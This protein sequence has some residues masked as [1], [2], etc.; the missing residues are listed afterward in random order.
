MIFSLTF[1]IMDPETAINALPLGETYC[2]CIP[3]WLRILLFIVCLICGFI[4]ASSALGKCGDMASF[5]ILWILGVLAAFLSTMFI[6]T[7]KE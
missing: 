3:K 7:F 6:K 1:Y 4:M 2:K 5:Y